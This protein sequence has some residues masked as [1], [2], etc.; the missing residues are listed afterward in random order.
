MVHIIRV[1]LI[2][3]LK[4]PIL[5]TNLNTSYK[6]LGHRSRE[7]KVMCNREGIKCGCASFKACLASLYMSLKQIKLYL[8]LILRAKTDRKKGNTVEP[9]NSNSTG[10][11]KNNLT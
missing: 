8:I 9:G 4:I 6:N 7:A 11:T 1:A 3:K 5:S 2:L 10:E